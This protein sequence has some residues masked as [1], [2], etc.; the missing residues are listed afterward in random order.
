MS[1]DCHKICGAYPVAYA[2]V[3]YYLFT[4]VANVCVKN[5]DWH[6]SQLSGY[7]QAATGV[8]VDNILIERWL[9]SSAIHLPN[10][11]HC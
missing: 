6:N 2:I 3:E 7:S 11:K 10:R 1:Y 8:Y 9:T 5:E 4:R